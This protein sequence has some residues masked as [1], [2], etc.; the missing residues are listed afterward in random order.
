MSTTNFLHLVII[1]ETER[2]RQ[3]ERMEILSTS[4]NIETKKISRAR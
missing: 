2:Q 3:R 1:R 4:A